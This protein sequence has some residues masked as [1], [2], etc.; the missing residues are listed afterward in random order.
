MLTWDVVLSDVPLRS[1]VRLV[2][3]REIGSLEFHFWRGG[4]FGGGVG[5]FVSGR[6]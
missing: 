5:S 4:G 2:L 3:P 6:K 1:M